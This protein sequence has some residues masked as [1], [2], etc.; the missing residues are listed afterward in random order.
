MLAQRREVASLWLR[1][2]ALRPGCGYDSLCA[3]GK[4]PKLRLFPG[5]AKAGSVDLHGAVVQTMRMV[6][7][8]ACI[9]Q[10]LKKLRLLLTMAATSVQAYTGTWLSWSG[11]SF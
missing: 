1:L 11:A 7:R 3:S 9:Q 10:A 2:E 5:D 6:S 8:T 4:L